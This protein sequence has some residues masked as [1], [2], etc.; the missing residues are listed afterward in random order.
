MPVSMASMQEFGWKVWNGYTP[1]QER[2]KC[3]KACSVTLNDKGHDVRFV[4]VIKIVTEG[5]DN[6]F[7][8][9]DAPYDLTRL[10]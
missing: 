8:V 10:L 7:N 4:L 9:F 6:Y 3:H 2:S 5:F 1:L